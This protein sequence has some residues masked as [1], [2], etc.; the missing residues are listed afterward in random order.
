MP[1]TKIYA[2]R[3]SAG[4]VK[5]GRANH[6][7]R[8]MQVLQTGHPG[9]LKLI[10]A[11]DVPST[12][13]SDIERRAHW[14]LKESRQSGEWFTVAPETAIEAI[15]AAVASR[16]EGEK[17]SFS[18]GR[19]PLNVKETKVRLTD[20]QR[21]RIEALVGPNRMAAFIREAIERELDRRESG[22]SNSR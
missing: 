22:S 10:Y 14:L 1:D 7:E 11:C 20:E 3:S 4:L 13:A 16:G 18:V 9:A 15:S 17:A 19:P 6:P 2:M 5:V 12:L 8:R 21:H